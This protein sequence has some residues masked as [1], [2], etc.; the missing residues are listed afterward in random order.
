MPNKNRKV[1]Q[2]AFVD[3]LAVE[4]LELS[5]DETYRFKTSTAVDAEVNIVEGT[6]NQLIVNG[7]LIAQKKATDT[8]TGC[9]ITMRDNVF[10]PEVITLLQ[11]GNFDRDPVSKKFTAYHA[12]LAGQEYTP[13]IFDLSM[14]TAQRDASG[15]IASYAKIT[16]PNCQGKPVAI[17]FEED[18]FFSPEY[19]IISMPYNGQAPY[20]IEIEDV[21]PDF[22]VTHPDDIV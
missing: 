15:A 4:L 18:T 7:V 2:L 14:Y 17:G 6:S 19:E 13:R 16:F 21:L 10:S 8:I 20:T 22:E 3:V 5:N 12:P 11:G 9:T 1:E